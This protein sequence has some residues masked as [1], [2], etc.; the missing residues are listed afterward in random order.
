[1]I[2]LGAEIRTPNLSELGVRQEY[3]DSDDADLRL[4]LVNKVLYM[5]VTNFSPGL[6]QIGNAATTEF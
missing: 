2:C 6:L 5:S 3:V 1:M 4:S